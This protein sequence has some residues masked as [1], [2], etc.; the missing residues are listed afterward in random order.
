VLAAGGPV[1]SWSWGELLRTRR[2][3]R[4]VQA[5]RALADE[6]ARIARE[7]HDVVAHNVSLMVIQAVAAQDVF[8]ARPDQARQALG[9]IETSGRAAMVELR[10][11]V[12][13][14]RPDAEAD[15]TDPQPGLGQL[16]ALVTSVRAAGLAVALR[17]EGEQV[18]VPAGVDLSAYRIVQEALT[19]TLRHARATRAAGDR[20]AT[21]PD[22]LSIC[23]VRPGPSFRSG[24]S[25][26]WPRS[27][28]SRPA[29]QRPP[30][31]P[32]ERG[33][34]RRLGLPRQATGR[35]RS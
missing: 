30:G 12:N 3:R 5:R 2:D 6:P 28:R 27:R 24:R 26:P 8:D 9:A 18:D 25:R 7:L 20:R 16:D 35:G 31:A 1:L 29:G 17:R 19:N 23:A 14:V 10:R 22:R 13:T 33:R 15:G 11:L 32:R 34:R 21:A 4:S